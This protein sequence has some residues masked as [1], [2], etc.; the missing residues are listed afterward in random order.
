MPRRRGFFC[1]KEVN[2]LITKLKVEKILE[3]LIDDVDKR[4]QITNQSGIPH[5]DGFDIWNQSAKDCLEQIYGTNH[6]NVIEFSQIRYSRPP[7]LDFKSQLVTFVVGLTIAQ[8][9]L[10]ATSVS[11][12][13]YWKD[14]VNEVTYPII[15]LAA[16]EQ[17][18]K[19][20]IRL[21]DFLTILGA[22]VIMVSEMPNL[23]LSPADKVKYYMSLCNCGLALI[24]ADKELSSGKK[25]NSGNID[26]EVGLMT[27]SENIGD[28]IIYLKERGVDKVSNYSERVHIS[29]TKSRF[30]DDVYP[31]LVKEIRS[32]GFI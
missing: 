8:E 26:N 12:H 23:N 24:T 14:D 4:I 27:N 15:F 22:K 16:S 1:G 31:S 21:K 2:I 25:V 32:F 10:R 18:K 20:S 6:R 5:W 17:A 19:Y 3:I 29:F 30:G 7:A 11:V 28:K 9:K 13:N